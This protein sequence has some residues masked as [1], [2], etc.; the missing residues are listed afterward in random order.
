MVVSKESLI[1]E[2]PFFANEYVVLSRNLRELHAYLSRGPCWPTTPLMKIRPPPAK[3]RQRIT[4][5]FLVFASHKA[6]LSVT[7]LPLLA[8]SGAL[9]LPDPER[10]WVA[11]RYIMIKISN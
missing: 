4:D 11:G 1:P 2:R 8:F 6:S 9:L 3:L 7:W 10:Q 5:H